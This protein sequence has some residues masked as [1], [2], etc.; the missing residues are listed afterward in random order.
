[1]TAGGIHVHPTIFPIRAVTFFAGRATAK[2]Q[3]SPA[4]RQGF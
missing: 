2:K 1:M 3:K 4:R